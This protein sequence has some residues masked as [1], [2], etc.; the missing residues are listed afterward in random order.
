MTTR[1]SSWQR[2]MAVASVAAAAAWLLGA[3]GE[4]VQG[5]LQAT[6]V[7]AL[8]GESATQAVLLVDA[9]EV[10]GARLAAAIGGD[11][12]RLVVDTEGVT[13]CG[14]RVSDGTCLAEQVPGDR[15]GGPW[16]REGSA[17]AAALAAIDAAAVGPRAVH[18]VLRLPTVAAARVVAGE[19]PAGTFTGRVV[20]V[21][22]SA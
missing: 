19:I 2:S 15:S 20:V 18:Y 12:P 7:R 16:I 9:G 5:P 14:L 22:R 4:A 13:G 1:W 11:G 3:V 17:A 10:D 8:A 6:Y 21:G